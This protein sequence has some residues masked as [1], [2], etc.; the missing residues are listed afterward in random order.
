MCLPPQFNVANG[1]QQ[2][3]Q[4][5]P[6]RNYQQQQFQVK[7][8]DTFDFNALLKVEEPAFPEADLNLVGD[9]F[10][11]DLVDFQNY[12]DNP[13]NL[14]QTLNNLGVSSANAAAAAAAPAPAYAELVTSPAAQVPSFS[15][16]NLTDKLLP[17]EQDQ[18]FLNELYASNLYSSN[19]S[20]PPGYESSNSSTGQ[21]S[22]LSP[23][24]T[25]ATFKPSPPPTMPSVIDFQPSVMISQSTFNNNNNIYNH[26]INNNN[27]NNLEY[28]NVTNVFKFD[29]LNNKYNNEQY[30]D[31]DDSHKN[32]SAKGN[33]SSSRRP[34]KLARDLSPEELAKTREFNR[35]AAKRHRELLKERRQ[36]EKMDAAKAERRIALLHQQVEEL[37][38][39]HRTLFRLV[40]EMYGPGGSR[41]Q[42]LR[43]QLAN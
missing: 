24:W 41:S 12:L 9:N 34:R 32:L 43:H 40:A 38:A 31:E 1:Q 13:I 2:Q 5:Q 3:Q 26:N 35:I 39:E 30:D 4:Y 21:S 20:S 17:S 18:Q 8:N 28:E 14:D 37:R 22:T 11:L 6:Q 15:P 23:E 29:V 16:Q 10:D 42:R 25:Q 7:A 27:N 19:I 33:K 36:R